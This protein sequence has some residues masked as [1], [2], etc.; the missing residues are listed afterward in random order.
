MSVSKSKDSQKKS[1][2]SR[3]LKYYYRDRD[4][5]LS[6]NN[7]QWGGIITP[8]T[9]RYL[10]QKYHL[11]ELTDVI[12]LSKEKLL[13]LLLDIYDSSSHQKSSKFSEL[14]RTL[15]ETFK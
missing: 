4:E 7:H 13:I 2:K 5:Q 10:K 15:V 1:P 12:D 3:T 11:N 9:S 14:L 6:L 8:I